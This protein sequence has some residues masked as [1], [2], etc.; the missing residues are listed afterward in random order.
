VQGRFQLLT[1]P[2]GIRVASEAAFRLRSGD[3]REVCILLRFIPRISD[4]DYSMLRYFSDQ[5]ARFVVLWKSE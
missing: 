3:G 2:L 5:G 1:A 4:C